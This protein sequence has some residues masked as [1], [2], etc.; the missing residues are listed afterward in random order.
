MMLH[1]VTHACVS[2][3]Y[4]AHFILYYAL[5]RYLP[6]STAPGGRLWRSIRYWISRPLFVTCGQNVNVEPGAHIGRGVSIGSNSGIGVRA[7][8][9]H[10]TRIGSNVMMGPE[11][12]IYTRNHCTSRLD[13]PMIQ[14]GFRAVAPVDIED[15]VW[16]GARVIILPGVTIGSGSVLGA[17]SV[18][19]R[20]VPPNAI[21]V[22]NP[23]RVVRYRGECSQVVP[24]TI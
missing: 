8:V 2:V 9:D 23:G 22:G 24:A 16:I 14:Q 13:V 15:N 12:M 19:S 21:V 5:G 18:I 7:L 6:R 20:D 1:K 17:G 4:M 11:V 10:K 3:K